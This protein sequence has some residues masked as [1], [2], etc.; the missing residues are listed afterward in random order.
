MIGS[1]NHPRAHGL[2]QQL[3]ND[4][5]R[6]HGIY[7]HDK[8]DPIP[9]RK[10]REAQHV[11]NPKMCCL[12]GLCVCGLPGKAALLLWRKLSKRL[13]EVFPDKSQSKLKLD[14]GMVMLRFDVPEG[15]DT[16]ADRKWFHLGYINR[17]TYHFTLLQMAERAPP[18][19]GV[20]PLRLAAGQDDDSQLFMLAIHAIVECF[21]LQRPLT[22]T[23]CY[24]AQSRTKL[25]QQTDMQ[26]HHV[27]VL[28]PKDADCPD[29]TWQGWDLEKP[30]SRKRGPRPKREGGQKGGPANKRQKNNNDGSKPKPPLADL[31]DADDA[32][33]QNRGNYSPS[34]APAEPP[35][36][37]DDRPESL[38]DSG[39][40][41][42]DIHESD[43][44]EQPSSSSDANIGFSDLEVEEAEGPVL[45]DLNDMLELAELDIERFRHAPEE[46]TPHVEAMGPS[47]DDAFGTVDSV[48]LLDRFDRVADLSPGPMSEQNTAEATSSHGPC[49]NP[50]AV[51]ANVESSEPMMPTP[52]EPDRS[53]QATDDVSISPFSSLHDGADP[54]GSASDSNSSD[55]SNPAETAKGADRKVETRKPLT[56]ERAPKV[57]DDRF[58]IDDLGSIRYNYKTET[59]VAFCPFHTGQCRR[60]RTTK[61]AARDRASAQGR[62]LGLLI[63]WL[64][65]ANDFE[66]AQSH[67]AQCHPN[68]DKRKAARAHFYAL[69]GGEAWATSYERPR[70]PGEDSE[71]TDIV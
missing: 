48:N 23:V 59:L 22:C 33:G 68:F 57:V 24:L 71:P 54:E 18:Q 3:E 41:P 12:I 27:E 4:W 16:P 19:N 63:A 52:P 14:I 28:L 61:P 6:R 56:T 5:A 53:S 9:G 47:S 32:D 70:R 37:Q 15:I 30:R 67:S 46:Q 42:D 11:F 1:R 62:P 49:S 34:I 50:A 31:Q 58:D 7:F 29:L 25:L 44:S 60:T 39:E 10:S 45:E 35:D 55:S 38:N 66:T 2:M 69:E 40:D 43:I 20:Q 21:D 26:P 8:A 51:A 36:I 17:K 13:R 65:Q 64:E